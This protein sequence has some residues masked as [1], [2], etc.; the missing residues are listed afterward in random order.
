MKHYL[1]DFLL[2]DHCN[3]TDLQS[4]S[5]QKKDVVP[6]VFR[7]RQGRNKKLPPDIKATFCST[8][9]DH[10]YAKDPSSGHSQESDHAPGHNSTLKDSGDKSLV[11]KGM[12]NNRGKYSRVAQVLRPTQYERYRDSE[13]NTRAHCVNIVQSALLTQPICS[14]TMD[15]LDHGSF[16][17]LD[18]SL[19]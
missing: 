9:T 7:R 5:R 8:R 2:Q 11:H 10:D 6:P 4:P 17:S 12:L 14:V 16:P 18:S 15:D 3:K 13:S 19:I 1:L